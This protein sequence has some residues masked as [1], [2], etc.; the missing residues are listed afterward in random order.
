MSECRAKR[1]SEEA[2]IKN[3][4]AQF[5]TTLDRFSWKSVIHQVHRKSKM[6][7]SADKLFSM[8][9]ALKLIITHEI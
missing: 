8:C 9:N 4:F 6:Y 2:K 5:F 3:L 1:R 7:E